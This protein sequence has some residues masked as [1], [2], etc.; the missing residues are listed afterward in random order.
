MNRFGGVELTWLGHATCFLKTAAGT[1]VLIDPWIKGNPKYP[2]Q[3]KD[4]GKV[5]LMLLTHGHSDHTGDAIAIAKQYDP[6]TIC[7]VELAYLLSAQGLKMEK[8]APMNLG[9]KQVF[10]DLEISMVEAKHSSSFEVDGKPA[11]AGEAGGFMVKVANGPTIYFAGDTALYTDMKLLRELYAPDVAVLPIGDFY[12]MGAKHAAIAAEWLGV[13]K[14]VPIHWGTF[15]VLIGTP[16]ELKEAL[17]GKNIEV[18]EMA[19]GEALS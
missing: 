3:V 16:K 14:V 18:I 2:S 4:F 11:Y 5:D 9:G 13:K 10:A 12:T 17:A 8:A 1:S 19:P 15:P 7:M 6:T